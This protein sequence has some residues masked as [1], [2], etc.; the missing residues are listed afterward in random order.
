MIRRLVTQPV[1]LLAI[2]SIALSNASAQQ[3]KR[4]AVMNFDYGTVETNVMAMFGTNADI[5]KGISDLVVQKLVEDGNYSVIER[6]QLDKILGEQNFANS[7]RADPSTA[8]KI[9]RV[10]G[11]DAIILGTITQFGRDDQSKTIGGGAL[12]GITGKYGIGG[13]SHKKATATVAITARLIDTSTAEIL[14]VAEGHGSESR[15]GNSILGA[16]G[17]SSGAGGGNYDVASSNFANTILGVALHKAVNELGAQLDQDATKLPTRVVNVNGLVADVTGN[18]VTLN[19]GT[20]AGVKVGDQLEIARKVKDIRD[21]STGKIIRTVVNKLGTVTIT[22]ADTSSSVG[23]FSGNSAPKVGD[24]VR[25][26]S[27][28]E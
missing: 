21:P 6:A 13:F 9:G 20:K 5:G 14:A 10:L 1:I 7:D 2:A 12:G 25:S 16:G 19:V 24:E 15:S 8:A 28:S 17:S 23:T 22:D 3:K 18:T 27:Q 11:V 26:A 4:V